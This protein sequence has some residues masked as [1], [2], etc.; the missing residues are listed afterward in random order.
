[1]SFDKSRNGSRRYD[2]G[3]F[4]FRGDPSGLSDRLPPQNLDAERGVLGAILLDNLILDEVMEKIRSPD[5]FYRDAHVVV[6]EEMMAMRSESKVIDAITLADHLVRKGIY[7]QI[8]GDD[9]LAEIANSVPHAANAV[10]HADIVAQKAVTRH[11]IQAATES[12]RDAYSNQFTA[13]QLLEMNEQKVFAL[14][15]KEAYRGTVPILSAVDDA[16]DRMNKVKHGGEVDWLLTGIVPLDKM[17]LGMQ[18]AQLIILAGR[19]G[20]GKSA[21]AGQIA[22]HVSANPGQNESVLLISLEMKA[23]EF[24]R[25]MIAARAGINS[26]LMKNSV[27]LADQE[28]ER[29]NQAAAKVASSRLKIDDTPGLNLMKIAAIARRWKNKDNLGMLA[30]DYLQLINETAAHG[31]NR[32]EIIRRISTGLKRLAKE[33][34]IPILALAQLNRESEKDDRP[35][36][37]SDLREGGSIE[38]DADVV[39]LLHNKTPK[40]ITVGPVDLIVEKNRDG[41]SAVIE[42]VFDRAQSTFT[43]AALSGQVR[44]ADFPDDPYDNNTQRPF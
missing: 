23:V 27:A 35:P 10:Y 9:L 42:L 41:E 11:L 29:I 33:L 13:E 20:A 6:Y 12:I 18:G 31:E 28:E 36:R 43:P 32:V 17:L 14:R 15:D 37:M 1:M 4:S 38:Q 5:D 16:M 2:Q 39:L 26:K 30:I 34:D 7:K 8:G 25:R 40:G 19:P 24:A 3:N 21:M 22:D 44:A